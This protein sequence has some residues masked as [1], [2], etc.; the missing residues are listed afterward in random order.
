MCAVND[1]TKK[2]KRHITEWE[3]NIC[4]S[5]FQLRGFYLAYVKYFYNLMLI[6]NKTNFRVP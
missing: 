2:A 5:Y 6:I 1:T 4:K 3:K